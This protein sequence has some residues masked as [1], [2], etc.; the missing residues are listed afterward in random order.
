M[1][2]R[3]RFVLPSL[4]A[5]LAPLGVAP[6]D[7]AEAPVGAP[8]IVIDCARP[9][10]PSQRSVGEMTGQHNFGQVYATRTRLMAEVRR[11]CERAGTTR[12]LVIHSQHSDRRQLASQSAVR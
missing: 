3:T 5:V 11:A 10:L 2:L 4:L 7:A 12:V 6:A 8:G 1:N 9:S